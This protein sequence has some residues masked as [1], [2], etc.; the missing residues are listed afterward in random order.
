MLTVQLCTFPAAVKPDGQILVHFDG[1]TE[2]YNYWTT[3]ND[4]HLHPIGYVAHLQR[5]GSEQKLSPPGGMQE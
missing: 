5:K 1:W 2:G 4:P 3:P